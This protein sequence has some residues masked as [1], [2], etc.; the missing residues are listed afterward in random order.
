MTKDHTTNSLRF[1]VVMAVLMT[2]SLG[3]TLN[4]AVAGSSGWLSNKK[5]GKD[6][7]VGLGPDPAPGAYKTPGWLKRGETPF[8]VDARIMNGKIQYKI[9]LKKL[10]ENFSWALEHHMTKSELMKKVQFYRAPGPGLVDTLC[11]SSYAR[12]KTPKGD[13]W[14]AL[15][16]APDNRYLPCR[17]LPRG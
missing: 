17:K 8:R 7:G 2:L 1:I 6:L 3:L 9:S 14:I 15:F 16:V 10:N 12:A 5:L 13:R 11:L 4:S